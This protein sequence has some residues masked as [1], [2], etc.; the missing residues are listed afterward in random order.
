MKLNGK[1][2][3]KK[4]R[5]LMASAHISQSHRSGVCCWR[6]LP[7]IL[8]V[9]CAIGV[10][11]TWLLLEPNYVVSGAIR[12]APAVY[13]II[14]GQEDRGGISDYTSFMATQAMMITSPQVMQRVADDL[15]NKGL[16]FFEERTNTLFARLGRKLERKKTK[17]EPEAVLKGA[18]LDQIITAEP[19]RKGELIEVI[20]KWHD[21]EDAKRI[22]DA[23]IRNYM[24]VEVASSIDEE[25]QNLTVLENERKVL[26]EKLQSQRAAI[27]QLAQE[28]GTVTL[29]GRQNMMLQRVSSLLTEL[30]KIESHRI[31]LETQVQLLEQTKE[32]TTAPEELVKMRQG[33]I[34]SDLT[35]SS[36][37]ANIA[38]LD[39]AYVA[40]SQTLAPTDPELERKAE[41][42]K[43]L[44]ERLEE[45]KQE[46]GKSFDEMM[47]KEIAK[48][49]SQK[50]ANTKTEL[51]QTKA[52]ENRLREMLNKEEVQTIG[53]GQKELAIQHLQ[54][55][56][57]FT[58]EMYDR[59][60]R[61]IT[62]FEMERKRP[63]RISIAYTADIEEIR[64][65]RG[66]YTVALAI[67]FVVFGILSFL[68]RRRGQKLPVEPQQ[69]DTGKGDGL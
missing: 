16:A 26:T 2:R 22:V 45:R 5:F 29:D 17:P 15:A 64:D 66:Y 50:L 13:N 37:S 19:L 52:Y 20:M 55:E 61:R 4:G 8:A 24:A 34:N 63:S 9:L 38:Q 30:T 23:F 59:I 39:Q 25:G 43:A 14:T 42:L 60:S 67:G 7:P 35:V 56:L 27:T 21:P 3:V 49:G 57:G 31:S 12:V 33:Y 10:A 58:K 44:K 6:I 54:D 46:A 40:A 48:A 47:N 65:I 28:Y 53:L 51:E 41:L 62:E 36:L 1:S 69:A 68:L 32:Q 18:I 11:A